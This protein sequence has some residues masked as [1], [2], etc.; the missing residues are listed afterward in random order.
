M[1]VFCV[2]YVFNYP[3][4][5]ITSLLLGFLAKLRK[6]TLSIAISVC[7]RGTTHLPLDKSP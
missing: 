4:Q 5:F 1:K 7:P 3:F 2:V 6:A